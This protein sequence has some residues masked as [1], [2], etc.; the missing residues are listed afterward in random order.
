MIARI[1][2]EESIRQVLLIWGGI[3]GVMGIFYT[4]TY[5]TT[6]TEKPKKP[7]YDPIESLNI[8]PNCLEALDYKIN[9]C[10]SCQQRI[11]WD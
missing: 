3:V 6:N 5:F 4:I 7:I 2:L 8:C 1:S 11:D 10:S 9:R